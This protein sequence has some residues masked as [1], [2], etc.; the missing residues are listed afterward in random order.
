[1]ADAD[2]ISEWLAANALGGVGG[3]LDARL[4]KADDL[5][6][7][8]EMEE[9]DVAAAIAALG[10]K[11]MK[12]RSR[13]RRHF[14]ALLYVSFVVRYPNSKANKTGGVKMAW[15]VAGNE[16]QESPEGLHPPPR[17]RHAALP[18]PRGG[19]GGHPAAGR[20]ADRPR[21]ADRPA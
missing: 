14:P 4:A 10:L 2:A 12:V 13:R 20:A 21:G 9:A 7:L 3:L 17:W 8:R 18:R 16:G 1:M 6:D 11:D 15:P 5:D 19:G